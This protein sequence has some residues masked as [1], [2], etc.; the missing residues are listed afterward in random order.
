MNEYPKIIV[1]FDK[2]PWELTKKEAKQSFDLF[3]KA[4]PERINIFE[5]EIQKV[6]PA[7]KADF[8]RDS[9]F[10]VAE[11]V[12]EKIV[13]ID[14]TDEEKEAIIKT[15]KLTGFQAE[16]VRERKIKMSASSYRIRYDLAIY[17]G[18]CLRRNTPFV[19]WNFEKYKRA[20]SFNEPVLVLT[21]DSP[22][23]T[24]PVT[25]ID[26]AQ[27]LITKLTIYDAKCE[28][29]VKIFDSIHNDLIGNSPPMPKVIY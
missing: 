21:K 17:F 11:W 26:A 5:K 23:K 27:G 7:W 25:V 4:I 20:R 16:F 2:V 19:E 13:F 3:L 18:E 28:H 12:K 14:Y 24:Y 29:I 15:N 9:L 8:T 10:D 6:K 22:I 1:P